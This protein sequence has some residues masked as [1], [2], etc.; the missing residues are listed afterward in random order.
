[1]RTHFRLTLRILRRSSRAHTMKAFMGRLIWGLLGDFVWFVSLESS[2]R[3][4]S[5]SPKSHLDRPWNHKMVLYID[6]P[7]PRGLKSKVH[8][9]KRPNYLLIFKI[10]SCS[11]WWAK[12][13]V[14]IRSIR[15]KRG[16]R[17][18]SG[19]VV[20]PCLF[21]CWTMGPLL[22]YFLYNFKRIHSFLPKWNDD[23]YL[24]CDPKMMMIEERNALFTYLCTGESELLP[25]LLSA[26]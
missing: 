13:Q 7:R 25:C 20:L 26:Q 14:K 3:L 15:L 22:F 5:T 1:M 8:L 23:S 9:L 2:S 19:K 24:S 18:G 11:Y 17:S 12:F 10:K 6:W 21:N 16:I 4:P